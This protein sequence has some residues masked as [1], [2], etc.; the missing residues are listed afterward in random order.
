MQVPVTQRS[1]LKQSLGKVFAEQAVAIRDRRRLVEQRWLRSHRVWMNY[2][3]ERHYIPSD[4]ATSPYNIPAARKALERTIVRGVRLLTPN[5]KWFEVSPMGDAPEQKLAN[6]DKF[7]W[8]VLRKRIKSRSI[9]SQLVRCAL[10]YGLCHLKTSLVVRNGQVWPSQRVVD[11]FA[12]YSF[13]ETASISDQVEVQFEDYLLSY[14]KYCT[15]AKQGKVDDI[16]R[17]D[18]T[19]PDWPYH[20]VE[21][22]AYQGITDP[23]ANVDISIEKDK[24]G[25]QLSKTT[26]GFASMTEMWVTREDKLFQVY[27]LWNHKDGA[28]CVGFFQSPYDEPLYRSMVHR[29][30]PGELYT[31]SMLADIDELDTIQND[32]FNMFIDA[33]NWEQGFIAAAAN[34]RHDSWKA[35]GRAVWLFD[36][37]PRQAMQFVQP[38]ITSTNQLRAWQIVWGMINSMGGSGTL[39]EGQ[40]GRNMP[41]AGGAV[42]NLI[43]LSMADVQDVAEIIEQEVLTAGLSDIYKVASSF[44]PDSQLMRIPGGAAFYH[45]QQSTVLKKT[46]ILGDYEFEWVGSLQFQDDSQRAQ[47]LLIFLNLMPQIAPFLQ[48]Q[49]Y[50]PNMVEL[51]RMIW[52]YGL[53]ERGLSD[54]VVPIQQLQQ[55]T[56]AEQQQQS[57]QQQGGRQSGVP[58]LSYNLPTVTN[59]FVRQ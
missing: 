47:R 50:A 24:V 23:T 19:K 31:S 4:T 11:P 13:P 17:S 51:L 43:E 55:Q 35:K 8:Y 25:N 21:R 40:P 15:F 33:V 29:S 22:L 39:A 53:G 41:R 9:I 37:D 56:M 45:G 42:N 54:V 59:G 26:A 36:D 27:I 38:P 57:A 44:I 3:L 12:F 5:V 7:M 48:Q 10:M 1:D 46:D 52:R 32:Q 18:L 2:D 28:R 14:E 6:V 30:I 20:L 34:R 58:G 16:A 49:G